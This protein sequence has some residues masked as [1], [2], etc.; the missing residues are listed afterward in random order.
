VNRRKVDNLFLI[1]LEEIELQPR[2]LRTR[3]L[4]HQS[5]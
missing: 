1:E 5:F 4:Y 3:K 2:R